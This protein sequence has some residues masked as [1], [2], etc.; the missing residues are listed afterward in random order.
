MIPPLKPVRTRGPNDSPLSAGEL[1]RSFAE[2]ERQ[3]QLTVAPPLQLSQNATGNHIRIDMPVQFWARITQDVESISG[4]AS[5]SNGMAILPTSGSGSSSG[6]E[7][8]AGQGWEEVADTNCDA[9]GDIVW[10]T[11][12]TFARSSDPCQVPAFPAN[13]GQ[14]ASVGDIVFLRLGPSGKRYVYET[15]IAAGGEMGCVTLKQQT[16]EGA[17]GSGSG[18]QLVTTCFRVCAPGLTVELL[19]EEECEGT[20]LTAGGGGDPFAP[21]LTPLP[22]GVEPGQMPAPPVPG[23]DDGLTPFPPPVRDPFP[24]PGPIFESVSGSGG[25]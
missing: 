8:C 11:G 25:E 7:R 3:H 21:I 17:S 14:W 23:P 16:C 24:L 6:A 22:P 4:S 9:N 19:S 1:N 15:P 20:E 13:A 18:G 12:P 2:I 5:C 10:D